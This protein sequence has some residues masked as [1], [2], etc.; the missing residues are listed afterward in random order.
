MAPRE[1]DYLQSIWERLGTLGVPVHD[2]TEVERVYLAVWELEAEVM[3]GGL[4]QYFYNSAGS[5]A[6]TAL[7]GLTTIGAHDTARAFAE[8]IAVF[9][10]GHVPEGDD[11]RWEAIQAMDDEQLEVWDQHPSEVFD[12]LSLFLEPYAEAHDADFLGPRTRLEW[13]HARRA[14]GVETQPNPMSE[15]ELAKAAA[16]DAQFTDRTCP[17]CGQPAPRYRTFCKRCGFPHGEARSA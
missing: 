13:W 17:E 16:F 3:N 15:E 6:H 11:E 1:V 8:A 9:P 5:G 7:R 12:G 10:G 4:N 14:R 2:L